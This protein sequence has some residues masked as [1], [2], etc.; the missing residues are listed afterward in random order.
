MDHQ[1]QELFD[2]GLKTKGFFLAHGNTKESGSRCTPKWG[3]FSRF[4]SPAAA[5]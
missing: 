2:F 3:G 1:V 5:E 4:Q